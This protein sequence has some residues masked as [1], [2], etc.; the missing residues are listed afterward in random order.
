VILFA[1]GFAFGVAVW[2]L[3]E[4]FWARVDAVLKH[5]LEDAAHD[6]AFSDGYRA[7][8]ADKPVE[9]WPSRPRRRA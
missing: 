1:S 2:A 3:W 9:D 8:R 6:R 4:P 7:G 5:R